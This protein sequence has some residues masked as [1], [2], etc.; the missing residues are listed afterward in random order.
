MLIRGSLVHVVL[1]AQEE[2]WCCWWV[3]LRYWSNVKEEQELM[4]GVKKL[5]RRGS[6]AEGEGGGKRQC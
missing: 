4:V 1:R 3:S 6:M 5:R 2:T